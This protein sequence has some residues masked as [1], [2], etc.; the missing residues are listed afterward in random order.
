MPCQWVRIIGRSEP[1]TRVIC[2]KKRNSCFFMLKRLKGTLYGLYM[3]NTT[4]GSSDISLA[5]N[6]MMLRLAFHIDEKDEVR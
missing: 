3:H 2:K 5:I 1:L 6:A 4:G